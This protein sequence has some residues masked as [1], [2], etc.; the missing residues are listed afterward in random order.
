MKKYILPI[1]LTTLLLS[2]CD[3]H[4]DD[5]KGKKITTELEKQVQ[6]DDLKKE[7]ECKDYFDKNNSNIY[8]EKWEEKMGVIRIF[9]GKK[10]NSCYFAYSLINEDPYSAQYLI[11]DLLKK[12]SV[13]SWIILG[14][15]NKNDFQIEVNKVLGKIKELT[16]E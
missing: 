10:S 5:E 12:D 14:W 4:L 6:N 3:V 9:Y 2:A 13:F 16:W 15:D 11:D 1:L 7:I 8:W